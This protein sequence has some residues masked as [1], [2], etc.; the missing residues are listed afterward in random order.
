VV[1]VDN[2]RLGRWAGTR[3]RGPVPVPARE[4]LRRAGAAPQG[5]PVTPG[6]HVR[7]R[8]FVLDTSVL[9]SD[10]RAILRFDEHEVVLPLVVISE[11]EAKRSHPSSAT[12]R[13]ARCGCST[14]CASAT[15]VSTR[16][17]RW[18]SSA[19]RCGSS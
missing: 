1:G 15:D 11:L 8:T 9:L 13:A 10:P 3:P 16:Y 2:A 12:S 5:G 17:C 14:R 18:G 6:P 19:A 7:R 4:Q